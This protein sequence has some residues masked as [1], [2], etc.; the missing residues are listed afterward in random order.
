MMKNNILLLS[1]FLGSISLCAQTTQAIDFANKS[2][3]TVIQRNVTIE[4]DFRPTINQATKINQKP[5][6]IEHNTE[7]S[8]LHYS[9]FSNP[10]STD[11]NFS[12]LGYAPSRFRTTKPTRGF[13]QGG[14]GHIHSLAD[15]R[16]TVSEKDNL[17]LDLNLH[18]HGQWGTKTDARSNFNMKFT[19]KFSS[20]ALFFDVHGM[21]HYY[22]RYGSLFNEADNK[23]L[24]HYGDITKDN[25]ISNW[26]AGV[27]LGVRSTPVSVHKY[28]VTANYDAYII[29]NVAI[30]HQAKL[31]GA[32]DFAI[33]DHHVG[34]NFRYCNTNFQMTDTS[35]HIGMRQRIHAEPFYGYSGRR[36]R[37][38]AGVNLDANIERDKTDFQASPNVHLEGDITK[39][40][41]TIF[42]DVK[43][44]FGLNS[45]EHHLNENPY[46][47][48]LT[49]IQC[50]HPIESMPVSAEV[51]FICKPQADLLLRIYADYALLHDQTTFVATN[52]GTKI[53]GLNIAKGSFGHMSGNFQ[54]WKIGG[55]LSY[56]YQDIISF[57][58]GGN[59]YIYQKLEM[60]DL[61]SFAFA[62]G[63]GF[64]TI[65]DRP[66]WDAH[67]RIDAKINAH[68]S[69]YSDN[70]FAGKRLALV[71]NG[72]TLSNATLR[73][74]IDLNLGVQY[75]I[76]RR[77]SVYLQLNNFL[78]RKYECFYGYQVQG[79]NGLAGVSWAF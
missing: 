53:D 7:K 75:N 10:L 17:S 45:A 13:L 60:H 52:T 8:T 25:R 66:E 24:G 64:Q 76:D 44:S 74:I 79:I 71:A 63:D 46:F 18:H 48:L 77:L 3:D 9:D 68:W 16:Y 50:K 41:L 20:T 42:A 21:N 2:G 6:A 28:L 38:H 34:A 26:K 67:L 5:V 72:N 57:T 58:V 29:S 31:I 4:R 61:A 59:Y 30:Q 47:D 43:G 33:E 62:D 27:T 51:G 56:H 73:E 1:L 39:T 35:K 14:V 36:F 11:F 15:F 32:L 40:W 23:Y 12:D 19:S 49:T 54:R 55:D 78:N 69:L 22:T 65:Y 70:I 37:L